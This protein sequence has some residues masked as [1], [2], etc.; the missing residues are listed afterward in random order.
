LELHTIRGD[1]NN[2]NGSPLSTS[3]GSDPTIAAI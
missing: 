1:S 2:S 3:V